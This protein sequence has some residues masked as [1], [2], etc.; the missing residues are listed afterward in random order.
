LLRGLPSA[1]GPTG[2]PYEGGTFQVSMNVPEQYPLTP[3]QVKFVTKVR[4]A[5]VRQQP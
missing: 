3:P 4:R 1:Q 2:T 5:S